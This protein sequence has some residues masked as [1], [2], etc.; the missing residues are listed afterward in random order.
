M[1]AN[2]GELL[3]STHSTVAWLGE[4]NAGRLSLSMAARADRTDSCGCG[5]KDEE[6]LV[7]RTQDA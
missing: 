3:E 5:I 1:D 4:P 2:R 7:S 6:T